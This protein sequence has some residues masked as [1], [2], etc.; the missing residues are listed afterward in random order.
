MRKKLKKTVAIVLKLSRIKS[1]PTRKSKV[2]SKTKGKPGKRM[3]I[4]RSWPRKK[5]TWRKSSTSKLHRHSYK[6][7]KIRKK[8]T[9]KKKTKMRVKASKEILNQEVPNLEAAQLLAKK[10]TSLRPL[11]ITFQLT[12]TTKNSMREWKTLKMP[13]KTFLKQKKGT[14]KK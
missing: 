11:P 13:V 8:G 14:R 4:K 9:Q 10:P 5:L 6:K 1:T 2:I 3:K 12:L 7:S